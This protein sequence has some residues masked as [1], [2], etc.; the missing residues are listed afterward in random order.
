MLGSDITNS[1]GGAAS[2]V[3]GWL[4]VSKSRF[5]NLPSI[6]GVYERRATKLSTERRARCG[7]SPGLEDVPVLMRRAGRD[8]VFKRRRP[9]R[10]TPRGHRLGSIPNVACTS[11]RES[12]V[13]IAKELYDLLRDALAFIA[14]DSTL[15]RT[16][17]RR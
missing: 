7:C 9:R 3:K 1:A 10:P 14:P 16:D 11:F 12:E 6:L 2:K 15:R 17:N 4:T 8:R 13:R 5:F